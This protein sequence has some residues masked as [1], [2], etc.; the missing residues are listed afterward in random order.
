MNHSKQ[1]IKIALFFVA[2]FCS[3]GIFA[4]KS[5]NHFEMKN[6]SNALLR[7]SYDII[8]EIKTSFESDF[9][10]EPQISLEEWMID[11]NIF[12]GNSNETSNTESIEDNQ[13]SEPIQELDD[14]MMDFDWNYI[15]NDHFHEEKLIMEEWMCCPRKW[16]S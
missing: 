7:S 10:F 16:T 5:I 2:I 14:W 8:S 12:A 1:T 13:F 9:F 4:Q 6:V 15:N 3:S 11:L